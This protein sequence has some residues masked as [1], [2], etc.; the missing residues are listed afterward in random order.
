MCRSSLSQ[1]AERIDRCGCHTRIKAGLRV[2]H[3]RTLSNHDDGLRSVSVARWAGTTRQ[4]PWG[5]QNTTRV[6]ASICQHAPDSLIP[7]ATSS[8]RW[9][10]D[11]S[12]PETLLIGPPLPCQ[13]IKNTG[14]S[15]H[16][17]WPGR[18][19][20]PR[21]GRHGYFDSKASPA[22]AQ[23]TRANQTEPATRR[24]SGPST[25]AY[26]LQRESRRPREA[27]VRRL[28][29]HQASRGKP[30]ACSRVRQASR[31]PIRATRSVLFPPPL[32]TDRHTG[33]RKSYLRREQAAGRSL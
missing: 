30:A 8:S 4:N 25:P 26:A 11:D 13:K 7:A 3:S 31:S 32:P 24:E 10:R 17:H 15:T 12:P 18:A 2:I 27:F 16:P 22:P 20:L 23:G 5:Q 29:S 19:F 9:D 21:I 33:T 6:G 14:R 28:A 1:S